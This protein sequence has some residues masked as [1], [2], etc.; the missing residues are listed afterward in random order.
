MSALSVG[1]QVSTAFHVVSLE[2]V[3]WLCVHNEGG[4]KRLC[5]SLSLTVLHVRCARYEYE[6]AVYGCRFHAVLG[7]VGLVVMLISIGSSITSQYHHVHFPLRTNKYQIH[8]RQRV[9]GKAVPKLI[10]VGAGSVFAL[11]RRMMNRH[12][13]VV[14]PK[15]WFLEVV[16]FFWSIMR[17]S[18]DLFLETI[19]STRNLLIAPARDGGNSDGAPATAAPA[20]EAAGSARAGGSSHSASTSASSA[21]SEASSASSSSPRMWHTSSCVSSPTYISCRVLFCLRLCFCF[22]SVCLFCTQGLGILRF[23]LPAS[24]SWHII[25]WPD[26]QPHR[27]NVTTLCV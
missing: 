13:S 12:T 11:P 9:C 10:V 2:V 23:L 1:F 16:L 18:F 27:H 22:L 14:L 21:V 19:R 8:S 25:D 15:S 3:P 7:I 24:L 26:S 5:V 4:F 6:M 20:E 17:P